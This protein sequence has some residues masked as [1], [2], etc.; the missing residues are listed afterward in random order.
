MPLPV[1]RDVTWIDVLLDM[2][3]EDILSK[4]WQ[5]KNTFDP[6]N[7]QDVYIRRQRET[8][9]RLRKYHVL[10]YKKIYDIKFSVLN[11]KIIH[12]DYKLTFYKYRVYEQLIVGDLSI[13]PNQL[14]DIILTNIRFNFVEKTCRYDKLVTN[15]ARNFI[16]DMNDYN[17]IRVEFF[18]NPI[19]KINY[20]TTMPR[21]E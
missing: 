16:A 9:I 19:D 18:K 11:I 7:N 6:W 10:E 12:N 15:L 5:Y 20:F 4:H 17:P 2:P 14:P 3:F 8:G 21:L 1:D 13:A